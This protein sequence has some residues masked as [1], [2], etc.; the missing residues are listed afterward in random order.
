[1]HLTCKDWWEG[2]WVGPQVQTGP[3]KEVHRQHCGQKD[4]LK[5][6]DPDDAAL[7]HNSCRD[8]NSSHHPTTKLYSAQHA[9]LMANLMSGSSSLN[10]RIQKSSKRG[11]NSGTL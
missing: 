6:V 8:L 11:S 2:V 5:L 4:M 7:I 1:M 10:T 9:M 3:D